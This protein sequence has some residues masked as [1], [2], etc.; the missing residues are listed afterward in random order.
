[1]GRFFESFSQNYVSKF[2]AKYAGM[3]M[4][5]KWTNSKTKYWVTAELLFFPNV[6]VD[7]PNIVQEICSFFRVLGTA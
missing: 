7:V 6:T 5:V 3:Y 4:F 2:I 1:M